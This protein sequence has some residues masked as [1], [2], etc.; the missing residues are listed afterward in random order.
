MAKKAEI[1]KKDEHENRNAII[2]GFLLAL[3]TFIIIFLW[4][5][6]STGLKSIDN[7]ICPSACTAEQIPCRVISNGLTECTM[8]ACLATGGCGFD[9]LYDIS[10][11]LY[12]L[13][14][15]LGVILY[16]AS[17][18]RG[19][20]K[21]DAKNKFKLRFLAKSLLAAGVFGFVL[22]AMWQSFK[23]KI[24]RYVLDPSNLESH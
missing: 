2:A 22:A 24:A 1:Q 15:S 16:I 23:F 12:L 10:S 18:S 4:V 21:F 19:I 6:S 14:L 5:W 7:V 20:E 17:L 3:L 11:K 13:Y 9:V 8:A